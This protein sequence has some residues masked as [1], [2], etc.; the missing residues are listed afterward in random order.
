[1]T[2]FR[3][4]RIKNDNVFKRP[5]PPRNDCFEL[6][7]NGSYES[8]PRIISILFGLSL[9]HLQGGSSRRVWLMCEPASRSREPRVASL[10]LRATAFFSH[11]FIFWRFQ[12]NVNVFL[13]KWFTW[14]KKHK[15]SIFF[16]PWN[17]AQVVAVVCW[18][19]DMNEILSFPRT[20]LYQNVDYVKLTNIQIYTGKRSIEANFR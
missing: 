11:I 9:V 10:F 1:M 15:L 16:R 5:S 17:S 2:F 7:I 6:L 14:Q 20:F 13:S 3:P 8:R 12:V 18:R 4:K 19:S